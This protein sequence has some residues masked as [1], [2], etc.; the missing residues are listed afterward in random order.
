M[1]LDLHWCVSTVEVTVR[2]AECADLR[3][4]VAGGEPRRRPALSLTAIL[5]FLSSVK[6]ALGDLDRVAAWLPVATG[7]ALPPE[8]RDI[9]GRVLF[10]RRP[11]TDGWPGGAGVSP[12]RWRSIAGMPSTRWLTVAWDL[13]PWTEW[14]P[15]PGSRS[16]SSSSSPASWGRRGSKASAG[17]STSA[18]PTDRRSGGSTLTPRARPSPGG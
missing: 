15:E 14:W 12:S 1:L 2:L 3:V 10:D 6:A 5:A 13:I 4:L 8:G 11:A 18:P 16:S 9:L 7:V 17:P